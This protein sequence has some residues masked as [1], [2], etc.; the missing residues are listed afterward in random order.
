MTTKMS[1]CGMAR[2]ADAILELDTRA[3]ARLED[4]EEEHGE[5]S[6]FRLC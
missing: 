4:T 6:S 3:M 2:L 1:S 5:E